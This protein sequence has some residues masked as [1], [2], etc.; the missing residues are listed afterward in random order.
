MHIV[1]MSIPNG[2]DRIDAGRHAG[3]DVTVET[4]PHYLHFDWELLDRLG[5]YAKC[6][7]PL[8][9]AIPVV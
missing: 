2:A 5:P 8:R 6:K 1:R 9:S 3:V 7:P 4:C